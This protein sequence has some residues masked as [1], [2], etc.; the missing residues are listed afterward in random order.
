MGNCNGGCKSGNCCSKG[1]SGRSMGKLEYS[2]AEIKKPTDEFPVGTK[3][4]LASGETGTIKDN[5]RWNMYE[6][7]IDQIEETRLFSYRMVYFLAEK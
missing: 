6:V 7:Y 4:S 1:S 5:S 3:V 2:S